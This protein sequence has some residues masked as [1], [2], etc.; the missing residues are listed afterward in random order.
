MANGHKLIL[1]VGP[2]VHLFIFVLYPRTV[3]HTIIV[4]PNMKVSFGN[5][6]EFDYGF[7]DF[8]I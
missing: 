8:S 3:I 2:V 5:S 4:M 7:T 1:K 6:E